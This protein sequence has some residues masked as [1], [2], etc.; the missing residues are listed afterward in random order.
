[1]SIGTT[2][3]AALTPLAPAGIAVVGLD[4]PGAVAMLRRVFRPRTPRSVDP[5]PADRL[6]LGQVFD[7]DEVIDDAIVA[8]RTDAD[9]T[10]HVRFSVHGGPRVVQ[11]LIM[12][13]HRCGASIATAEEASAVW[14]AAHAVEREVYAVLPHAQTRRAAAWLLRQ[15]ELLPR[16]VE[17]IRSQLAGEGHGRAVGSVIGGS[18]PAAS[19]EA[20]QRLAELLGRY[21][22][23]R[24]MIAGF[25]V[26]IIGPP[27]AGKS[28]LANALCGRPRVLVSDTPGTTRDYV[29]E[30][31]AVEGV[32][33]TLV[34][35]AG[36]RPTGDPVEAEA[37]ARARQQARTADLRLIVLDGS[38]PL[39]EEGRELLAEYAFREP[40]IGVLNKSDLSPAVPVDNAAFGR[41][42]VRLT[43][44]ALRGDGMDSLRD[45][46]VHALGVGP[47]FDDRPAAF[48]ERQRDV[49]A[50][51]A[52]ALGH[53]RRAAAEIL[54]EMLA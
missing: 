7:G 1:M 49:L 3:V 21:A 29:T 22:A 10:G 24:G 36:I 19:S 37:I 44:S 48:T 38:S 28:T 43:V 5:W 52:A 8:V 46:I 13:L 47:D 32:P 31:T 26:A 51:C 42:T 30:P 12:A 6:R 16:A 27:N 35:T 17:E 33:I 2:Q 20:R 4:G 53:G 18:P 14:P 45:C 15:R 50:R 54:G 11:R 25:T 39:R 40:S 23:A 41:M 9:G 34:D